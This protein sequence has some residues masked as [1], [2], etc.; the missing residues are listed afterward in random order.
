MAREWITWKPRGRDAYTNPRA[1]R[2]HYADRTGG[3]TACGRWVPEDFD[4]VIEP[5][6]YAKRCRKCENSWTWR[7]HVASLMTTTPTKESVTA[8]MAQIDRNE[9]TR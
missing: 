8:F 3:P 9:A 7:R 4:A 1:T 2:A 5:A 6:P